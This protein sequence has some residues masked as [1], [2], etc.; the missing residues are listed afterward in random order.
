MRFWLDRGISGFRL[1]AIQTLYEDPQLRN[2]PQG[3]ATLAPSYTYDLP[4]VHDVLRRL[5]TMVASY[6]GQR[7]LIGELFEPSMAGLDKFYGGEAKDELQLPMD[8]F[9]GLPHLLSG[10]YT[11]TKDTLD[12]NFYRVACLTNWHTS[13]HGI[14]HSRREVG[15]MMADS[16]RLCSGNRAFQAS[17]HSIGSWQVLRLQ[18]GLPTYFDQKCAK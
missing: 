16:G 3:N 4:E 10:D 11:A 1:D 18:S 8:Y 9:F 14:W 5:H 2:T 17:E 15:T 7:V 12:I 6:P 13:D